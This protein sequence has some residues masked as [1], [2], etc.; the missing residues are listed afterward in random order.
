MSIAEGH[1]DR[2][3]LEIIEAFDRRVFLHHDRAAGMVIGPDEIHGL[4]PFRG[5]GHGRDDGVIF[6]RQK[7]GNDPV[8]RGRDDRHFYPHPL[9]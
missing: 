8:E 4:L 5:N 3:I 7:T 9:S 2:H 6:F 1:A